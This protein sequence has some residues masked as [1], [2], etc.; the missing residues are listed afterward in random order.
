[1]PGASL[2]SFTGAEFAG[3]VKVRLGP[4]A[5]LYKGNGKFTETDAAAHQALIEASGKDSRATARRPPRS[6]PPCARV[7]TP[8]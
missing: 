3:T 6:P 7:V 2:T 4:I 1:M 5:L 8:R